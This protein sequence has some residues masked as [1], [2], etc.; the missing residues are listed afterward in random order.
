MDQHHPWPL[1]Q[2][3]EGVGDPVGAPGWQPWACGS[4]LA[5]TAALTCLPPCWL[6]QRAVLSG[7]KIQH[8]ED[9]LGLGDTGQWFEVCQTLMGLRLLG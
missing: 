6:G 3:P 5:F 9:S 1:K 7:L 8:E 4:L 2:G